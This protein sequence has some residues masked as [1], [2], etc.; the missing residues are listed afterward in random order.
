M[1]FIRC[2]RVTF[3]V[4]VFLELRDNIISSK[5]LEAAFDLFHCKGVLC[6]T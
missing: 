6:C 1:C 4:T 3:E 2:R 5:F